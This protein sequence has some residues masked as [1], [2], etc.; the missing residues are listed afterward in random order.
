MKQ[1]LIRCIK[2]R[3]WRRRAG[4]ALGVALL[5]AVVLYGR[6]T[7][8]T[9][10]APIRLVVYGFS[11]QQE[12]MTQGIF[13]AF[14]QEWLAT[15]G[16]DLTIEG[17][18]GPSG[19]L[20]GQINLGAPADI[21]LFSN[22]HHVTWLKIGRR[23]QSDI[24]PVVVGCT[25]MVIVTRPGN[26]SHINDFADL[27]Q[28]GLR[29]LHADPRTSGAGDWAVLAEY[30]SA[31]W[32]AGAA[33]AVSQPSDGALSGDG[34][35]SQPAE[36]QL[37]AI[38]H[39]VR[40][41]GPSARST[42]TLFELGAGDAMVTYEQDARLA[43]ERGVALEIVLPPRTIV[44][45]H[46]AV[47]VDENV[48]PAELPSVQAFLRFLLSDA[49]QDILGRYH[50]RPADLGSNL[51]PELIQPFAVEDLGGWW[52]AYA[53]LVEALWEKDIAPRLDLEPAPMLL[54]TGE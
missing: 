24:E 10:S 45:Q 15:T 14:E 52:Q 16:K 41:L 11:T 6:A 20:A 54:G 32:S 28:P 8:G 7:M 38:W 44:A 17:V 39:N 42:L 9:E 1:S 37:R 22:A 34:I 12:V 5:I 21:A 46:V 2:S 25:P 35:S 40:L 29:L 30:G 53:Q 27:A 49:G 4:W 31:L 36:A 26:P 19:T 50:L 33:R 47:I 48:T 13:P 3:E 43:L 51:F 23:V 18:F